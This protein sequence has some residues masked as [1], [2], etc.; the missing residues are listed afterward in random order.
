MTTPTTFAPLLIRLLE[1][2]VDNPE[3]IQIA[4]DETESGITWEVAGAPS[5]IKKVIGKSGS[6][7]RALRLVVDL[8]GKRDGEEW[9]IFVPEPNG[10]STWTSPAI[11][12]HRYT[13]MAAISLLNDLLGQLGITALINASG[14]PTEGYLIEVC[15]AHKSGRTA[16][17]EMHE[18]IFAPTQAEKQPINLVG[19]LATLLR[20]VGGKN[21]VKFSI[22]VV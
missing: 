8:A 12:P 15:P 4:S 17:L 1:S 11:P 6:R 7:L 22:D 18:A 21:G 10:P 3:R 2:M 16:L 9:R 20:G 13:P 5:D 19:S 14:N